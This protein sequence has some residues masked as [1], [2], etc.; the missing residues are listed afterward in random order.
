MPTDA[1]DAQ[2]LRRSNGQEDNGIVTIEDFDRGVIET[3]GAQPFLYE[4]TRTSQKYSYFWP[5]RT[6][7]APPGMPG[8]PILFDSGEDVYEK[9][10]IPYVKVKPAGLT[11][12]MHRYHPMTV[13]FR[14][15][16]R[17][18][19]P[20]VAGGAQGFNRYVERQQ[21]HPFDLSYVLSLITTR[22]SMPRPK[23]AGA[24]APQVGVV[25]GGSSNMLL[26]EILRV[27]PAYCGVNVRDSVGDYRVYTAFMEGVTPIDQ[28]TEVGDR[29]I[30][31]S[32]SLRIEG[33][34]DLDPD[35]VFPA[36]RALTV[37]AATL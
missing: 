2:V 35:T 5:L 1:H 7:K 37:R 28:V 19:T 20:M 24:G 34:L 33:E 26:T 21:A 30:G 10:K 27:Y 6:V 11:P 8:V 18:A 13:Q 14:A 4:G 32:I 3:L 9:F 23:A 22:R 12:A 36:A 16:A 25:E 31:Y 17:T 29:E 15:P